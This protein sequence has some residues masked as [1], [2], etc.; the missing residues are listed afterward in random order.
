MVLYSSWEGNLGTNFGL[1][2]FLSAKLLL[3]RSLNVHARY[4]TSGSG[5]LSATDTRTILVLLESMVLAYILLDGI[6]M[7]PLVPTANWG[8]VFVLASV[9]TCGVSYELFFG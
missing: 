9:L 8:L 6:G 4:S 2:A 7:M 3:M 5:W 1:V